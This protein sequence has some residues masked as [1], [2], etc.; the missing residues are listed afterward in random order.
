MSV[1]DHMLKTLKPRPQ[2]QAPIATDMFIPNK[3]GDILNHKNKAAFK[4]IQITNNPVNGYV[5]TSDS[6]GNGT[7]QSLPSP[8]IKF[9]GNCQ[10]DGA[11]TFVNDS[12]IKAN[13]LVLWS[14]IDE[15][16]CFILSTLVSDGEIY[17][18]PAAI[19]YEPVTYP[20]IKYVVMDGD[21]ISD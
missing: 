7:W 12:R 11:G 17:F 13:D 9:K 18:Y 20:F 6:Q 5:L 19:I 4:N 10:I 3:S 16:A 15:N 1:T 14:W 21:G 2:I 8:Q